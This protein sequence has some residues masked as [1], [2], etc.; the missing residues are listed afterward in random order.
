MSINNGGGFGGGAY[1][2]QANFHGLVQ[3]MVQRRLDVLNPGAQASNFH[4]NG[5]LRSTERMEQTWSGQLL[6]AMDPNRKPFKPF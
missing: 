1:P 6:H 5:I 3:N 2:G 4:N